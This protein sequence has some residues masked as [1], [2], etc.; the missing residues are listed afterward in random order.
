MDLA[1]H[2][3]AGLYVCNLIKDLMNALLS[4]ADETPFSDIDFHGVPES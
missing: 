2:T 1:L 4:S 3:L